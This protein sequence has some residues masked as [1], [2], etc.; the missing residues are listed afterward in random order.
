MR[1]AIVKLEMHVVM[2]VDDDVE[3]SEIVDELDYNISDTTTK[4]DIVD[5]SIIDYEIEDSK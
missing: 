3:I 2:F 5:T 1:K 4:A